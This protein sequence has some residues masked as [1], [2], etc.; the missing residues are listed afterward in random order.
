VNDEAVGGIFAD[1]PVGRQRNVQVKFV[2]SLG[3]EHPVMNERAHA[4]ERPSGYPRRTRIGWKV[5]CGVPPDANA[6]EVA[7]I[8]REPELRLVPP[9]LPQLAPRG[10]AAEPANDGVESGEASHPVSIS[11]TPPLL[12]GV[13]P[14]GRRFWL[15]VTVEDSRLRRPSAAELDNL[16]ALQRMRN[17]A[18]HARELPHP[19]KSLELLRRAERAHGSSTRSGDRRTVVR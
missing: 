7:E 12:T 19:L 4:G 2:C 17:Y 8:P 11:N 9:R 16:A 13:A 1:V 14:L 5:A 10:D 18:K 3:P 15:S 6:V